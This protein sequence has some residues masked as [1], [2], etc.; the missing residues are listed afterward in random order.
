MLSV[1][2]QLKHTLTAPIGNELLTR[3]QT[4]I[5]NELYRAIE[6]LRKQQEWWIRCKAA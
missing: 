1:A 5:D 4:S 2:E 6:A 3:Y